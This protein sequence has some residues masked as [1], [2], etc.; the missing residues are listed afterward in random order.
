[1]G[2]IDEDDGDEGF[3]RTPRLRGVKDRYAD[4]DR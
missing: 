2:S 4:D 1:M 3:S